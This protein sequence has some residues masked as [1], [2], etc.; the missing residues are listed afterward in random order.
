MPSARLLCVGLLLLASGATAA[1]GRAP[2]E[3]PPPLYR[4]VIQRPTGENGYE[5]LV[6][7]AG[8]LKAHRL[9]QQ[10]ETG[11]TVTMTARRGL[12][13]DRTITRIVTLIRQGLNKGV[14]S[15]RE[16]PDFNTP[17]PELAGFRSLSRL[18]MN[19]ELVQLG[20][21]RITEAIATADL[22]VRMGQAVQQET[23]IGG[24]VGVA[25]IA[26]A[27]RPLSDHLDQLSAR[28]CELLHRQT[29]S[30]LR[31]PD[32]LPD[33][34]AGEFR[35]QRRMIEGLFRRDPETEKM[36]GEFVKGGD[37]R[38]QAELRRVIGSPEES[39]RLANQALAHLTAAQEQILQELRKPL[40]ERRFPANPP[41]DSLAGTII[42][43]TQPA[44][45][46]AQNSLARSTGLF[47][48]LACH[49]AALA[50]RWE[51]NAAPESL[52]RL[53][54]GT[55]AQDPFTG[56]PLRYERLG[57]MRFRLE[58]P[59]PPTGADDPAAIEGRRPLRLTTDP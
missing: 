28:D 41:D 18:I 20:D 16:E 30:W 51:H 22:G 38:R 37:A 3:T 58:S 14:R 34:L 35:A 56:Q 7:A 9:F 32:P 5:E 24:L 50:H 39:K 10:I 48:L 27:I 45:E 11:P 21:G 13:G 6:Y 55:L 47:R 26:I 2:T 4:E 36:L 12:M 59:G 46:Q 31:Q 29:L 25:M 40:W 54:L 52:E 42:S 8:L 1:P 49:T 44:I 53:A 43:V 19:L 23:L 33:L 57:S 15:P 17:L